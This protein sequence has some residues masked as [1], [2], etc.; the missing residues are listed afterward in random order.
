VNLTT[1]GEPSSLVRP[2]LVF[3]L[4]EMV[5]ITPT[6]KRSG[7]AKAGS[8]VGRNTPRLPRFPARV[9]GVGFGFGLGMGLDGTLRIGAATIRVGL[10]EGLATGMGRV[11]RV[12]LGTG[13]MVG[14]ATTFLSRLLDRQIVTRSPSTWE[15]MLVEPSWFEWRH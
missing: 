4:L 6:R 12:G 2:S 10:G 5:V 8:M 14:L 11:F 1:T 15:P 3:W 9:L 13:L 7:V